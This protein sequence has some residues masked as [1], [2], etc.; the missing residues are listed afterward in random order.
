MP[1]ALFFYLLKASL[2][3]AILTTAYAWLV[4][5]ETFLQ[6]NR[7]LLWLNV[8]ATLLLPIAPLP[9]FDWLPDAP[10]QAV[11]RVLPATPPS[12]ATVPLSAS[13]PSTSPPSSSA[14]VSL[15][16]RETDYT[17]WDWLILGYALVVGGLLIK[18]LIQIGVLWKLKI[19]SSTRATE[20]DVILVENP[21]ISSPFSFFSWIFF[22]PELYT[23]DE[24]NQIFTHECVHA[25]QRHS[26][27]ML[28]AEL[29]KIVFWFN[30]FAWWH[31]KLVQETLEFITDR[32]V[33]DSGIEKKSYQYHLLR[34]TLGNETPSITNHFNQSMLKKRIQMMNKRNSAWNAFGKYGL[35]IS[36]IWVC[37]A[38][39]KPY[40][41]IVK[42]NLIKKMPELQPVFQVSTTIPKENLRDFE[43]K[44]PAPITHLDSNS[45]STQPKFVST[46]Q[47]VTSTKY[48]I[49]R[50]S[51]VYWLVTSKSKLSDLNAIQQEL[52]KYGLEFETTEFKLDPL[53]LFNQRIGVICLKKGSGSTSS[54]IGDAE[55]FIPCQSISGFATIDKKGIMGISELEPS[56]PEFKKLAED[57]YRAS[58]EDLRARHLDYL[59]IETDRKVGGR[60]SRDYSKASLEYLRAQN[61][62]STSIHL[63]SDNYIRIGEEYRSNIVYL[64]G[65]VSSIEEIEKI[66][67]QDLY[68]ARFKDAF[69]DKKANILIFIYH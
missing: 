48:L 22:N 8:A 47:P 62:T 20:Y 59:V 14:P 11:A 45:I 2:V 23:E 53:R 41:E 15:S 50:D 1:Y 42:T 32:A 26:I 7:W 25:H 64:N 4:K 51:T 68:L 56:L 16:T 61:K 19:Q 3:L 43:W 55:L 36:A 35:F 21:K 69:R 30:P 29:L 27:D 46:S 54:A 57:D 52:N 37:A 5:K 6:V 12:V 13:V 65:R 10:A 33:L 28:S 60:G 58:L 34:N 24:W 63:S 39:T 49:Y 38:F 17:F 40:Q 31:Q 18:L 66:S 67:V 9:D 44:S